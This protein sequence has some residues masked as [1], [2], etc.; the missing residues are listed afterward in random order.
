MVKAEPLGTLTSRTTAAI[1]VLCHDLCEMQTATKYSMPINAVWACSM[2]RE[3]QLRGS[4][5]WIQHSL[6]R[7]SLSFI[8]HVHEKGSFTNITVTSMEMAMGQRTRKIFVA[9]IFSALALDRHFH[10]QIFS[11]NQTAYKLYK[12]FF[13]RSNSSTFSLASSVI[14]ALSQHL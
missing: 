1:S 7:C 9:F 14:I 13:F 2:P 5:R 4:I 6:K 11:K 3:G 8:C 10:Y 12:L